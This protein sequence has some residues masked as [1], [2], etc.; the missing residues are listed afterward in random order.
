MCITAPKTMWHGNRGEELQKI[1]GL[2]IDEVYQENGKYRQI[3]GCHFCVS[4]NYRDAINFAKNPSPYEFKKNELDLVKPRVYEIK[5]K[6]DNKF[7][8]CSYKMHYTKFREDIVPIIPSLL[9]LYLKN[10]LNEHESYD[11]LLGLVEL[12][13]YGIDE[14]LNKFNLNSILSMA[15]F[16]I[17]VFAPLY[18]GI[19]EF[20]NLTGITGLVPNATLSN[21]EKRTKLRDYSIYDI[22]NI[23]IVGYKKINLPNKIE[24]I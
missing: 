3:L 16:N 11:S 12:I 21:N 17:P 13:D 20:Y 9:N 14:Q 7:F 1:K 24:K 22:K 5:L 19:S 2:S 23:E 18:R 4:D 6:E 15:N 8:D 10:N